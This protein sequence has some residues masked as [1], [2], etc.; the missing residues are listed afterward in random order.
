MNDEYYK[1]YKI[2]NV[3]NAAWICDK[4][5]MD[6][7]KHASRV[8]GSNVY[9]TS[10]PNNHDNLFYNVWNDSMKGGL[11]KPYAMKWYLEPRFNSELKATDG[12]C[13]YDLLSFGMICDALEHGDMIENKWYNERKVMIGSRSVTELDG[14]FLDEW[15]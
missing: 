8:S 11:F 4:K 7:I 1:K 3:D 15:S 9:I 10:C 13:G 2:I 6:E 5:R 14:D 12:L